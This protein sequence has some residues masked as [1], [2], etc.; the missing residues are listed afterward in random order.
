[1]HSN[2]RVDSLLKDESSV[3][4]SDMTPVK[5]NICLIYL[6]MKASFFFMFNLAQGEFLVHFLLMLTT[7][8]LGSCR[9]KAGLGLSCLLSGMTSGFLNGSICVAKR[10]NSDVFCL[11]ELKIIHA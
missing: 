3:S 6:I 1:M 10:K 8:T 11:C 7:I 4:L 2:V 5:V 9:K